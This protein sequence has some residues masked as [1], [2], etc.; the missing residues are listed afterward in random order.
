MATKKLPG[1]FEYLTD[2][3]ED[4]YFPHFLVYKI[5]N[6][7]KETVGF[8]EEGNHTKDEI[9]DALDKMTLKINELQ[10]EFDE[11]DSEIETVAGV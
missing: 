5:K 10:E 7:I 1:D 8:I 4:S 9:Q 2:M 6:T 3:Y 11:N